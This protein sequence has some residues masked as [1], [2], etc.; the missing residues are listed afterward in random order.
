MI[1]ITVMTLLLISMGTLMMFL[2]ASEKSSARLRAN[3]ATYYT[4]DGV[5][6]VLARSAENFLA[7]RGGVSVTA[8]EVKTAVETAGGG[9]DLGG[10]MPAGFHL[11]VASGA[12]S[13]NVPEVTSDEANGVLRNGPWEGTNVM[14]RSVWLRFQAKR[15]VTGTVCDLT[16]GIDVARMS[17]TE[18][19]V[20]AGDNL[21]WYPDWDVQAGGT[22]TVGHV[23]ANGD[24]CFGAAQALN[25]GRVTVAGSLLKA[26]DDGCHGG[27]GFDDGGSI[28]GSNNSCV[29]WGAAGNI[30]GH[31]HAHAD[32]S[33]P[34][35]FVLSG[36][37]GGGGSGPSGQAVPTVVAQS[38]NGP[39]PV[40]QAW[41]SF[42][43]DTW[44]GSVMDADIGGAQLRLPIAHAPTTQ[45]GLTTSNAVAANDS[46]L[47]LVVDPVRSDDPADV[48]FQRLAGKAD[49]RIIDGV[50]Y[51]E[52]GVTAWP[53]K[54]VWSDHPGTYTPPLSSDEATLVGTPHVGQN[55][56]ASALSWP[57][58]PALFSY[59]GQTST[60]LATPST[61]QHPVLSYGGIDQ[62]FPANWI[63]GVCSVASSFKTYANTS[64]ATPQDA[65]LNAAR[66]GFRDRLV[67]N[68]NTFGSFFPADSTTPISNVLPIN[69][70][71][72]GLVAALASTGSGEL[73]SYFAS[74]LINGVAAPFNGIVYITATW[75]GSIDA[76]SGRP[77]LA[78]LANPPIDGASNFRNALP[79]P[80]C[81]A[82]A[83]ALTAA[84]HAP[85]CANSA[86]R[87][88]AVRVFNAASVPDALTIATNLPMYVQ[89]SY[90]SGA[91]N[92][93]VAA[94]QVTFLSDTWSDGAHGWNMPLSTTAATASPVYNVNILAGLVRTPSSDTTGFAG[95]FEKFPRFLESFASNKRAQFHG[96]MAAGFNSVYAPW[97]AIYD[98]A[99][100][101]STVPFTWVRNNNLDSI[102]N[103]PPGA[104]TFVVQSTGITAPEFNLSIRSL[105]G[106]EVLPILQ[107]SS[108]TALRAQ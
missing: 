100:P 15:D 2:S 95:G 41:Q 50:W 44:G 99:H 79:Y 106:Q 83:P 76:G 22:D 61:T 10:V 101:T 32:G 87:P 45:P 38:D 3:R 19:A 66:G 93:M 84:F 60:G 39:D 27:S 105:A 71:V 56:L 96:S 5:G 17:L 69:V 97:P 33:L 90:G 85:P 74:R 30:P 35:N 88:G 48:K 31:G 13:F 86:S 8:A 26:T 65:V 59:Y 103:S 58:V 108:F 70:D 75:P 64:C 91:P 34:L 7:T 1:V 49:V 42:A 67:A 47:R 57:S 82:A 16:Q 12:P 18:F 94:D 63:D 62:G 37:L 53:G 68:R 98:V 80:L 23:Q 73:G 46:N 104:P 40:A 28:C 43:Q 4:C 21:E 107:F 78:P 20:Y 9:S 92:S 52:D 6:R 51:V 14:Q 11:N 36:L 72:A 29:T 81:D 54:A 25:L 55:D 102:G 24:F 89:G 77:D